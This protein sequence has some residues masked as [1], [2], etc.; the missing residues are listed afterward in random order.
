MNH[1]HQALHRTNTGLGLAP[2]R[3]HIIPLGLFNETLAKIFGVNLTC[4]TPFLSSFC[5][6]LIF[7]QSVI[8][9]ERNLEGH[10][11]LPALGQGSQDIPAQQQ[12]GLNCV[13]S[14]TAERPHPLLKIRNK[15]HR[16]DW[17]GKDLQRSSKSSPPV[18]GRE[19]FTSSKPHPT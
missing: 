3:S 18:M 9:R 7:A 6:E 14:P 4:T 5:R 15:N 12:A 17:V 13:Q 19:N 2:T 8:A 10:F 16:V 11:P 1:T